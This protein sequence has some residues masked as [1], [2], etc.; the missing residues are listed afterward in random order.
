MGVFSCILRIQL[1]LPCPIFFYIGTEKQR[2]GQVHT[3][4]ILCNIPNGSKDFIILKNTFDC[5]KTLW[6]NYT[7]IVCEISFD[8][9]LWKQ[10]R[11]ATFTLRPE[12]TYL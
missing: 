11:K 10:I 5:P 1:F 12:E 3:N 2:N 9:Q 8:N 6:K 7:V 4:I